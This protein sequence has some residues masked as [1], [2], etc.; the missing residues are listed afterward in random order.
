VPLVYAPPNEFLVQLAA[1]FSLQLFLLSKTV[2]QGFSRQTKFPIHQNQLANS[3]LLT[4]PLFSQVP[5]SQSHSSAIP[6]AAAACVPKEPIFFLFV[7]LP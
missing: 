5:A 2:V 6:V 3:S 4:R 1:A 7:T